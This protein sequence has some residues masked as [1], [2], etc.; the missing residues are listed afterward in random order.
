MA[1]DDRS[2]KKL[3]AL[4]K[5][6]KHKELLLAIVAV[7]I[8]LAVYFSSAF[9]SPA[10]DSSPPQKTDYCRQMKEDVEKAVSDMCGGKAAVVIS[11]ESGVEEIIAFSTSSGG[12]S[13]TSSPQLMTSQGSSSPIV[14]KEIYP[15]ALGAI[16]ICQG[17][18]N[19][20]T[21]L[22]VISAV[23]AL[24]NLTTDKISVFPTKK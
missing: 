4:F 1:K 23:S 22:D 6:F 20:K 19:V 11:W 2:I 10:K 3:V 9:K 17:G 15:K 12:G 13:V 8:M 21:K 16:I 18:D 14:L 5:D 7:G 24:L